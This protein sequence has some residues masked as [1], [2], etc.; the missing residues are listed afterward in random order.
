MRALAFI[1]VALAGL[2]FCVA[3]PSSAKAQPWN[4]VTSAG[5]V[6]VK[7]VASGRKRY[8]KAVPKSKA[9]ARIHRSGRLYEYFGADP[10]RY[11]GVGP[12]SYE[13]I[14]YDCTW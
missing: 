10:D 4:T 3:I 14:G 6:E 5:F 13:C 9:P 7:S 2:I 8:S 11:F 12:G 1:A